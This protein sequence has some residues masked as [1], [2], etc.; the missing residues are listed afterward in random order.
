MRSSVRSAVFA[1]AVSLIPAAPV[2]ILRFLRV[3][4][5]VW[6]LRRK[7]GRVCRESHA[8]H[9]VRRITAKRQHPR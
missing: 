5:I 2:D 1:A 3:P 7:Q 4:A 8:S 6:V 9:R